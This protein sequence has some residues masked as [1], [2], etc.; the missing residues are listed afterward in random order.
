[1]QHLTQVKASKFYQL[2][3]QSITCP[4]ES[5]ATLPRA[6]EETCGKGTK[7]FNMEMVS[8]A[9]FLGSASAAQHHSIA[10][11]KKRGTQ[12]QKNCPHR[13]EGYGQQGG[14]KERKYSE[15]VPPSRELTNTK[16]LQR[17]I[18]KPVRLLK[19]CPPSGTK[20]FVCCTTLEHILHK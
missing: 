9:D 7:C 15:K 1:M 17:Y 10:K 11:P 5:C 14:R 6:A 8:L 2:Y 20:I 16:R 13:K 19:L 4:L 18:I 12:P 3:Q